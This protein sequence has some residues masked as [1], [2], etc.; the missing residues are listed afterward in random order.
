[1]LLTPLSPA[2]G[3]GGT[4][5]ASLRH[6]PCGPR[7]Q[8]PLL[9]QTTAASPATSRA[10]PPPRMS[11]RMS[12]RHAAFRGL[13]LRCTEFRC[14]LPA[15]KALLCRQLYFH[16]RTNPDPA[17]ALG[18]WHARSPTNSQVVLWTPC[19]CT[20]PSPS[21]HGRLGVHRARNNKRL[22]QLIQ[23]CPLSSKRQ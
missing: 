5:P 9:P 19:P 7:T 23:R 21:A 15:L 2:P 11:H 17:F 6:A 20:Q 1:M 12:H 4:R 8:A 16:V 18:Q 13:L 14:R 10:L 22:S 3:R